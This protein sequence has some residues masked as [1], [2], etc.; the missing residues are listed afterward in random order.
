MDANELI[1]FRSDAVLIRAHIARTLAAH[2]YDCCI[3]K[4]NK[5]YTAV[6]II[7]TFIVKNKNLLTAK[8]SKSQISAVKTRVKQEI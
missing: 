3:A 1:A 5:L 8:I 4:L 7:I 2:I 6:I